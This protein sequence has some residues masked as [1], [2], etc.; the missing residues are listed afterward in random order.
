MVL[1]VIVVLQFSESLVELVVLLVQVP[2][3]P[4]E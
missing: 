3:V 2:L 4:K 1:L